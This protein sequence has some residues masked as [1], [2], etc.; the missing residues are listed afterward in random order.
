MKKLSKEQLQ[1]IIHSAGDSRY[2]FALF[3]YLD[4]LHEAVSVGA[5]SITKRVV[6]N[7]P[8]Q[9][10]QERDALSEIRFQHAEDE[11]LEIAR[12]L[13]HK[14][15]HLLDR[16]Y[17]IVSGLAYHAASYGGGIADIVL[18][19]E[20][21]VLIAVEVGEVRANKLLNAFWRTHLRE[22]WVYP[23]QVSRRQR[24]YYYVFKRGPEWR[25]LENY[26]DEEERKGFEKIRAVQPLSYLLGICEPMSE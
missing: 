1:D 25:R 2:E 14:H 10:P 17:Y 12:L 11:S 7:L 3:E 18:R 4:I 6:P 24:R 21:T 22:L 15:K 23:Y 5:L 19:F 8:E 16:G 13:F 9:S 20:D 26:L